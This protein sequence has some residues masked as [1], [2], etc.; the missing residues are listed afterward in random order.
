LLLLIG[1]ILFSII[2]TDLFY[3]YLVKALKITAWLIDRILSAK[4]DFYT[5]NSLQRQVWQ[6][7]GHELRRLVELNPAPVK[8]KIPLPARKLIVIFTAG[9]QP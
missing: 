6:V 8:K 1:I 5:A 7:P 2:A 3:H 4:R 9:S